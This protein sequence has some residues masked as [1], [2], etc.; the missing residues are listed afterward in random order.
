[1]TKW[2]TL[3]LCLCALAIIIAGSLFAAMHEVLYTYY[4]NSNFTT[5][6]G[7]QDFDCNDVETNFGSMSAYRTV[8]VYRCSDG[9][10]Q[11]HN[12]Q[13]FDFATLTWFNVTC[14]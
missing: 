4:S 7:W 1:M 12:C 6:V 9:L 5:S 2:K 14:P 3:R 8:D 13:E 11:N 10:H